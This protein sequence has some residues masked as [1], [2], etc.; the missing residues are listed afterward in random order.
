VV[1]GLKDKD[2]FNAVQA[3]GDGQ[4]IDYVT[5][6][7]L[8]ALLEIALACPARARPTSRAPTW[9]PPSSPASPV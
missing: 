1:I 4:F 6:P 3:R 2:K 9:S 5:H 8:P 7:T